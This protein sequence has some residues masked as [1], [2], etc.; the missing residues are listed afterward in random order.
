MLARLEA[1]PRIYEICSN[2]SLFVCRG[3]ELELDSRADITWVSAKILMYFLSS[4]LVSGESAPRNLSEYHVLARQFFPA[5][6]LPGA[7]REQVDSA[8]GPLFSV[9][10]DDD[11]HLVVVVRQ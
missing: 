2:E 3:F 8:H 4:G 1:I 11:A 10:G 5:S 9:D 7:G 6:Q